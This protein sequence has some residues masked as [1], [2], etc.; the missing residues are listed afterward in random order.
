MGQLREPPQIRHPQERVGHRLHLDQPGARRERRLGR[1][2]VRQIGVT[3]AHAVRCDQPRE[4]TVRAAVE[5]VTG[6]QLVARP[7]EA[8]HRDER[9]QA[10]GEG[11][12]A[13]CRGRGAPAAP[14]APR[15][16]GCRCASSRRRA[17]LERRGLVEGRGLVDRRRHRAEGV[18]GTGV[19]GEELRVGIHA[20]ASSTS[21]A[22]TGGRSRARSRR[23]ASTASAVGHRPGALPAQDDGRPALQVEDDAVLL[24][25]QAG[26][27]VR[28]GQPF[29]GHRGPHPAAGE[30]EPPHEADAIPPRRRPAGTRG[31]HR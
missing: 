30:L 29:G 21:P 25:A 19:E 9:G 15:A 3:H 24:V 12:G 1:G 4:Q 17:E 27:R 7:H 22:S 18:V 16:S 23:S 5:V 20:E 6:E 13:G 10:A 2:V 8:G 26:E 14:P 31:G 28:G 11:E